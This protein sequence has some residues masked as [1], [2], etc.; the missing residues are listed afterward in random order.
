MNTATPGRTLT[1]HRKVAVSFRCGRRAGGQGAAAGGGRRG[2]RARRPASVALAPLS[3]TCILIP[4]PLRRPRDLALLS[5]MKA[6]LAALRYMLDNG[7]DEKLLQEVG[8]WGTRRRAGGAL[9]GLWR[10]CC[11][12]GVQA[13]RS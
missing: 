7:A 12:R 8:A 6:A 5:V 2:G 1:Q 13:G 3:H 9:E 4:A 11:L 10:R